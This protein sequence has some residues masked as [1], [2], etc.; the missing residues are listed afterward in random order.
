MVT[1]D[2][3]DNTI[4]LAGSFFF[5]FFFFFVHLPPLASQWWILVLWPLSSLCTAFLVWKLSQ[6][7]VP[8]W[9]MLQILESK[10]SW[11]PSWKEIKRSFQDTRW[12][13]QLCTLWKYHWGVSGESKYVDSLSPGERK[14]TFSTVEGFPAGHGCVYTLEEPLFVQLLNKILYEGMIKQR[15]SHISRQA[16]MTPSMTLDEYNILRYACGYVGKKK[17]HSKWRESS[18]YSSSSAL[19]PCM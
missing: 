7:E 12:N 2:F 5:F 15:C 19:I 9:K 10:E 1:W 16:V 11:C 8:M 14:Q 13:Y 6:L 3:H 17:M 4:V 18:C